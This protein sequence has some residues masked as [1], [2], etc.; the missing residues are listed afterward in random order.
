MLNPQDFNAWR[1]HLRSFIP[2]REPGSTQRIYVAS[3]NGS[4]LQTVDLSPL[5]T[6]NE[7]VAKLIA[8]VQKKVTTL[9]EKGQPLL[10]SL[11][12]VFGESR[13]S[14]SRVTISPV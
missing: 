5:F 3:D 14:Q 1:A 8:E 7:N 6:A 11:L 2:E 4:D 10:S 9:K 12:P 13:Q